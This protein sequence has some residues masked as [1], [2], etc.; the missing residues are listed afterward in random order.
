VEEEENAK[1][2]EEATKDAPEGEV[3]ESRLILSKLCLSKLFLSN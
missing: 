2:E 3:R 1:I